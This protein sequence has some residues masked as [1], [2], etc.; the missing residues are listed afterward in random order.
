MQHRRGR[1]ERGFTLIE[2][3]VVVAIIA[4]LISILLPSLRDA[5]EQAKV[6]KCL[7]NYRQL[8]TSTVHY[9][10]DFDDHFP[11]F[12][13][14][15]GS[16][17]ICSW[18]Y[19]GKT[20]SDQTIG[21]EE[22]WKTRESGVYYIPVQYRPLNEYLM[23]G[24]VE[25]D[26]YPDGPS[27]SPRRAEIPVLQCPSDQ[28][29]HQRLFW[30]G[31]VNLEG[32]PISCYDDVGTSYHYNLHALFD[33]KSDSDPSFGPDSTTHYWSTVGQKLVKDVLIKHSATYTMYIE[34]P[35]DYAY[36]YGVNTIGNHGKF[37]RHPMGFLDGH[38]AY[39]GMDTRGWCGVGWEGINK[40]WAPTPDYTPTPL[41][42]EV[43]T[44]S[45]EYTNPNAKNCDIP[46]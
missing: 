42:Y 12:V 24:K 5:R 13:M 23:A 7:A 19:G 9:F 15:N 32:L 6:A 41:H 16:A 10:L 2:L 38:A 31:S 40:E 21:G 35:L 22:G 36:G 27:A 43:G 18:A 37:G 17:S 14:I 3:L 39:M 28:Y 44:N 29:S 25:L 45:Y 46:Q 11:F 1:A 8:T 34:D 30:G 20:A 4:L 33:V 26:L